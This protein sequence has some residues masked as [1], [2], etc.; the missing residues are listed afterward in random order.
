M[1]D[2][3]EQES[4]D[5]RARRASTQLRR[6]AS[7][8]SLSELRVRTRRRRLAP[9]VAIATIGVVVVGLIAIGTN[10]NDRSTGNDASRFHWLVTDLPAGWKLQQVLDPFSPNDRR[11]PDSLDSIY[12]TSSAP[13]GPVVGVAGSNGSPEAE[14]VPGEG[15]L[16]ETNYREFSIDG[17]R[18]AF[19]D[20]RQGQRI[21]YI[22]SD[23]HWIR[24]TSRDIDDATLTRFAQSAV[25]SSDGTAIIPPA[26]LSDGLELVAPPRT[27]QHPILSARV[28]G[29]VSAYGVVADGT[30][31]L[32][33]SVGRPSPSVRGGVA[34]QSAMV[35]TTISTTAGFSGS[36]DVGPPP[37][38][39]ARTLYWE[40]DGLAFYL[41]GYGLSET[42]IRAA[43]NSIRPASDEDWARL[44]D[45]PATNQATVGTS[46]VATTPAE[47]TTAIHDVPIDV[48]VTVHSP[49]SQTWSGTLPT[50]EPWSLD[51]S[52]VFDTISILG[53]VDGQSAGISGTTMNVRDG[54][55]RIQG[56]DG[57][58]VVTANKQGSAMRISR[59]NGDRYTIPLHD[60][61]GTNGLRVAALA[62]PG[63][64]AERR[65]ELIDADGTVIQSY[66]D[67]VNYDAN[68]KAI[69]P[70]G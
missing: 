7:T 23:G 61:P 4:I 31:T 52:R 27:A 41:L 18:A 46:P 10:R 32:D 43:A 44:V 65:I 59:S 29:G 20:N 54:A 34:L 69:T 5:D 64:S 42:E 66:V 45:A 53:E 1:S 33:L 30:R 48:S 67:G 60:L 50:G 17:R 11:P 62:L 9:I 13:A 70:T 68:G 36:F 15:T 14:I 57:G 26:N 49:T 3:V 22:E 12:A 39:A 51:L 21:L 56:F 58:F 35:P 25:R 6:T 8:R 24:L 63:T 40:H 2:F 37:V 38:V 55:T 28:D 16:D 19:A 47:T